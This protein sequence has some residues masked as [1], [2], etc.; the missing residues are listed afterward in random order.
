MIDT[1]QKMFGKPMLVLEP[2]ETLGGDK[3]LPAVR[4]DHHWLLPG[5][6][7]FPFA[8]CLSNLYALEEKYY[9][10]DEEVENVLSRY[11]K[12]NGDQ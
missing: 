5:D 7:K 2:G 12:E 4:F 6:E 9:G 10:L 3:N 1:G 8:V 11:L